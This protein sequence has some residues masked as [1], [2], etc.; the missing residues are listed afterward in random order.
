M[1][2]NYVHKDSTTLVQ[3]KLVKN[4]LNQIELQYNALKQQKF[5]ELLKENKKLKEKVKKLSQ[6]DINKDTRN[7]R[8]RVA[9]AKLLKENE[10]LKEKL[11]EYENP[12]NM[13]LMMMWCT[14]QVKDENKKL[15][16]KYEN[17]VVDYETT[18]AE[19]EQLNNLVNSCQEKIRQLKKQ[20]E[21]ERNKV[22]E[23]SYKLSNFR[24]EETY[25]NQQ[26]EFIGYMNKTIEELE[27]DD[28][29]DEE[30][31]GYLIQRIDT[32]KEILSKYKEIIGVKDE[33][34]IK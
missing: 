19:K 21:E 8:Q 6:W 12:E 28:V 18:M 22:R 9:N 4:E 27:C 29:D 34:N 1:E 24:C 32:F 7:S 16:K 3:D 14:E 33:N 30:I 20:L 10:E 26:K 15:K 11:D 25:E 2:A 13:T 23:Y 17:A 5:N 31:K